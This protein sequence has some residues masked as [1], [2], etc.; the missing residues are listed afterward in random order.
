MAVK[1]QQI[2]T[3]TPFIQVLFMEVYGAKIGG[4]AKN[5]TKGAD[6]GVRL[7]DIAYIDPRVLDKERA[8]IASWR[9]HGGQTFASERVLTRAA[10]ALGVGYTPRLGT[11]RGSGLPQTLEKMQEWLEQALPTTQVAL[12][13]NALN[14]AEGIV[15]RTEDRSVIAKARFED[16]ARTLKVRR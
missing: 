6:M 10:N 9:D 2:D 14:R 15:L 13:D 8:E 3:Y 5:Y 1:Q 12:S 7:F 16:Y 11:V 4:A